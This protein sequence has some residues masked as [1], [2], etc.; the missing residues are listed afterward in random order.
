MT[1]ALFDTL[2]AACAACT[3]S[4]ATAALAETRGCPSLNIFDCPACRA[5]FWRA[6][7]FATIAGICTAGPVLAAWLIGRWT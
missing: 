5:R 3:A 7:W 6:V 1:P 4:I 2:L